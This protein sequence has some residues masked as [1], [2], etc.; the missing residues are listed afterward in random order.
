MTAQTKI[1]VKDILNARTV[2]L[3]NMS[4]AVYNKV[5]ET[6]TPF[7]GKVVVVDYAGETVTQV[8]KLTHLY[9]RW[10]RGHVKCMTIEGMQEIPVT[11][12][13]SDVVTNSVRLTT[14]KGEI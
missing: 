9:E 10:A 7:V 12:H 14:S 4:E 8:V 11:I 2:A 13:Y 5:K 3:S 1:Q 6:L